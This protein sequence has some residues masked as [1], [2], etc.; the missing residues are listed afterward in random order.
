MSILEI[1]QIN[2]LNQDAFNDVCSAARVGVGELA[3]QLPQYLLQ[4]NK[5]R[6]NRKKIKNRQTKGRQIEKRFF[7]RLKQTNRIK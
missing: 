7:S 2:V 5:K 3:V 6:T 1:F 4:A